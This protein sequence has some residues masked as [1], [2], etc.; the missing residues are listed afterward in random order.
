VEGFSFLGGDA[1]G[2]V[3]IRR[4]LCKQYFPEAPCD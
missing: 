1:A 2:R 4:E 3:F